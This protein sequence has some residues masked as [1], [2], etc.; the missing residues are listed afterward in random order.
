MQPWHLQ[1]KIFSIQIRYDKIYD[2]IWTQLKI[3][4]KDEPALLFQA[5]TDI[6][7]LKLCCNDSR[8]Y[9]VNVFFPEIE[10][11]SGSTGVSFLQKL[12]WRMQLR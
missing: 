12:F 2:K 6:L 11:L 8:A 5:N 1:L 4:L 9:G 7:G 3:L 10:G